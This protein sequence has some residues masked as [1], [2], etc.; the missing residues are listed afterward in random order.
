M[1]KKSVLRVKKASKMTGLA[2]ATLRDPRWR[3]RHG[4]RAVRVGRTIGFFRGDLE[5]LL[6]ESI[7]K[8]SRE[9]EDA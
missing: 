7:E 5:R 2:E 1:G 6:N 9:V 3:E 8:F 4:L